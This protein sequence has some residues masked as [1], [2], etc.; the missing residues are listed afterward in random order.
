MDFEYILLIVLITLAYYILAYNWIFPKFFSKT[1]VKL[2]LADIV[3][4]LALLVLFYFLVWKHHYYFFD[5]IPW[6]VVAIIIG[7]A[8]EYPF[9]KK[10]IN[11]IEK[12]STNIISINAD[13]ISSLQQNLNTIDIPYCK[14]ELEKLLTTLKD[15]NIKKIKFNINWCVLTFRINNFD[16]KIIVE[17]YEYI[18]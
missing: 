2:V 10:F 12:S 15:S 1:P 4:S 3:V 9:F 11:Q 18:I 5:K 14:K 17:K 8:V 7:F 13:N 16:L 6:Y